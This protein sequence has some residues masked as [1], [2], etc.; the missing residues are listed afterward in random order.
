[1]IFSSGNWGDDFPAA[2]DWDNDEYTG[3]LSG[4]SFFKY[5]I[6]FPA[7][8][9]CLQNLAKIDD[10]LNVEIGGLASLNLYFGFDHS[11]SVNPSVF[12]I[13]NPF[14]TL[15]LMQELFI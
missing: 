11:R 2:E 15:I 14:L 1:M 6:Q 12:G 10:G 5:L 8:C 13:E 4:T 7:I 3:S 9:R